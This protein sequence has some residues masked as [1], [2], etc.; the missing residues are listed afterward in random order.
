LISPAEIFRRELPDDQYVPFARALG[1]ALL[2]GA[3]F[4]WAGAPLAWM[5]GAMLATTAASLAGVST[6]MP[7]GLRR[8][9]IGVLGVMLGSAFRPELIGQIPQWWSSVI[10]LLFFVALVQLIAFLFLRYVALFDPVTSYFAAPPGGLTEMALIG[11]SHGAD[12]RIISLVHATRILIVVTIIPFYFRFVEGLTVPT[13]P[14]SGISLISFDLT[15]GIILTI[16]GLAGFAI[17]KPLKVPAPALIGPMFVSAGVHLAGISTSPPPVELIAVAQLIVGGAIGA[18]FLGLTAS[19]IRRIVSFAAVSG[20]IMVA[21]SAVTS[22]LVYDML[23]KS[24]PAILLALVPGGLAEMS[25]I[26]LSLDIDVA[27]VSTM[28]ILRIIMV[29]VLAPLAFTWTIGR[30]GSN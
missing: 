18:R 20:L 16:G 14:P 1:F 23:G 25:L 5:L 19:D 30:A 11:E 24:A 26:A 27:F 28:H 7:P 4:A 8:I 21:V 17:A 6:Y 9:M 10:L 13:L 3:V 22:L 15:E 2:G 29:V 12:L